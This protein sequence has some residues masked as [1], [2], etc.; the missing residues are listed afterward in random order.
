MMEAFS[1]LYTSVP[2]GLDVAMT[3][4]FMTGDKLHCLPHSSIRP[5]GCVGGGRGKRILMAAWLIRTDGLGSAWLM[6]VLAG[7]LWEG[8]PCF[9]WNLYN[10]DTNTILT[11]TPTPVTGGIC[12]TPT[13]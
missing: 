9:V 11:P 5:P 4:L 6:V 1:M 3:H 13:L 12:I 2:T 10:T 7:V 8:F